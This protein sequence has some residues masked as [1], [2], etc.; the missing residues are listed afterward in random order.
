MC[1][2]FSL[3]SFFSFLAEASSTRLFTSYDCKYFCTRVQNNAIITLFSTAAR[4]C[5]LIYLL[6]GNLS[7]LSHPIIPS[8]QPQDQAVVSFISIA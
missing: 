4:K 7:C 2:Y 8:H 1:G 3:V 6:L 5:R